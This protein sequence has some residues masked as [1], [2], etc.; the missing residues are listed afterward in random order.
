MLLSWALAAAVGAAFTA[1]EANSEKRPAEAT[2]PWLAENAAR[3]SALATALAPLI[4]YEKA[5]A[6]AQ[7]A[8]GEGI[9]VRDAALAEGVL[10]AGTLDRVLDLAR[11][12]A[13]G[14]PGLDLGGSTWPQAGLEP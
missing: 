12:T 4:G 5:A 2:T 6:V 9:T 11:L 1:L 13:P 14:L 10:D 3:D 8:E 7:R